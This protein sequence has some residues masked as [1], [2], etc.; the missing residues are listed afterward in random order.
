MYRP[1]PCDLVFDAEPT[2]EVL[3][4]RLGPIGASPG[5]SILVAAA[6][7]GQLLGHRLAEWV[8]DT[9]SEVAAALAL[10]PP[11]VDGTLDD[12]ERCGKTLPGDGRFTGGRSQAR[13]A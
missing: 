9:H 11:D 7:R 12:E 3:S 10:Q 6:G 4:H 5:P 1:E 8:I 2:Q 13:S